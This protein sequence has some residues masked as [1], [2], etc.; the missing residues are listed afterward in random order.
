MMTHRLGTML[1][2]A[3]LLGGCMASTGPERPEG[4]DTGSAASASS[5]DQT[6]TRAEGTVFGALIGGLLG[7]AIGDSAKGALIGAAV[8]AGVGYVVGNEVAKRKA[9]YASEEDFLD[10]EIVQVQEFN[11]TAAQYNAQL[12]RKIAALDRESQR[13]A[14]QYRA[15][16]VKRDRLAEQRAEVQQ[17]MERSQ[18]LEAD[19]RKEHD[20]NVAVVQEQQRARGAADPQVAALEK[21]VQ[22]LQTNIDALHRGS[23]QLA[24][25][26][27]RLSL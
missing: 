11:A 27:E 3:A 13:L 24:Q 4:G 22:Q 10:G 7:V 9:K 15:G 5:D 21:E 12:A 6:R 2:A 16:K 17:R 20:I 8:G 25:I 26:D 18:R 1:L 23:T 19:L 14:T